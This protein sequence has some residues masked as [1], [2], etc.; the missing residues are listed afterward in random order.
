[1]EPINTAISPD[2]SRDL[3][4]AWQG[5]YENSADERL[6]SVRIDVRPAR[7]TYLWNVTAFDRMV[8]H[9][10]CDSA[11][12]GRVRARDCVDS[13]LEQTPVPHARVRAAPKKR[14]ALAR[15]LEFTGL[16][17]A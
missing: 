3:E 2:W 16:S 11:A 12:E 5:S 9:G 17:A 7:R 4:G 10:A 13:F 15:F 8:G 1:M 6:Q 14:S